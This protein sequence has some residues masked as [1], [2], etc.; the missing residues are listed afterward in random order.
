MTPPLKIRRRIGRN[1]GDHCYR[2]Q[3][4]RD[5]SALGAAFGVKQDWLERLISLLR[6]LVH[7]EEETRTELDLTG[8]VS[9]SPAALAVLT[10]GV[11][12]V[13]TFHVTARYVAMPR[14]SPRRPGCADRW[15]PVAFGRCRSKLPFW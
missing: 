8:L 14:T 7:M 11:K 1:A 5:R 4:R 9:M 3:R 2:V 12:P 10:A 15:T 13:S 6:P